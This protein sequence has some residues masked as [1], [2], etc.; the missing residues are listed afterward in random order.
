VRKN[1]K[2]KD[3]NRNVSYKKLESS[4]KTG[5][6][7]SFYIL[8][9]EERYLL[10]RSLE[11]LRVL[12][13]PDGLDSFNYKRFDGKELLIED[14]E[15]AID[16]FPAFADRSLIEIHDFDIFKSDDK[17]HLNSIFADLPDYVCI[18]FVY[19]ILEY[20]PDGRKKTDKEILSHANV[21]DFVVQE[22]DILVKW[23]RRH[24]RDAGKIIS[25][26]D[27]KYLATITG[28]FMATLNGE[29]EKAA[30]YAKHETVTREDIDAVVSPILDVVVYKLTDALV[31]RDSKKALHHLGELLQMREEPHKM[32][33]SISLKM[34]QLLTARI[35]VENR[36]GH[37]SL[38]KMCDF[39][40]DFQSEN[41]YKSARQTTL[42]YCREFVL[43][44][45]ATALELNSSSDPESRI[46]ELVTK[47]A[48]TQ[49]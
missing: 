36:I 16:T 31:V 13:C 10:D 9:G 43:C 45:S 11:K 8:H 37:E 22:Q 4:L 33:Y 21:V 48:F 17:E 26:S 28:G 32:M 49:Q 5:Q 3:V 47:L 34:R 39:R 35:F 24:F 27:I 40:Y 1:T 19:N 23:I 15:N 12:L 41:L 29:I 25:D 44:C 20:K 7:G 38:K 30:A 2:N 42:S 6:L 46:V 18:I 14:L